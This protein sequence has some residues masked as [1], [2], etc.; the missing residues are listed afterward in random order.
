MS[1]EDFTPVPLSTDHVLTSITPGGK[2]F[3]PLVNFL[4][5]QALSLHNEDITKTYV[6]THKADDGEPL[7]NHVHG[8]ISFTSS[9]VSF[10][11][12]EKPGNLEHIRYS[13]LPALKISRLL[14]CGKARG[15][16]LGRHLINFAIFL[17]VTFILPR[18]GCRLLVVD[19]KPEAIAFYERMGFVL[20]DTEENRR[21]D[22]P[23]M[24]FDLWHAMDKSIPSTEDP[25]RKVVGGIEVSP[26]KSV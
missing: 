16:R 13:S 25:D 2:S 26:S 4:R 3:R 14:V 22:T 7:Y 11:G 10:A 23:V 15:S 21:S 1:P 6:I 24:Y 12:T 19:S 5:K 17:A 9:E 18:I 8:Y 20:L